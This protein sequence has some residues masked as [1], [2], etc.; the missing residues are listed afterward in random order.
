LSSSKASLAASLA[1]DK[2]AFG[3]QRNCAA[4]D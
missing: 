1:G 3:R 2:A 4:Q